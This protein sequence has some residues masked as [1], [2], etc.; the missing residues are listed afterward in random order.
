MKK[1]YLK[2]IQFI[3]FFWIST[4][5]NLYSYEIKIIKKIGSE[6]VTNIDVKKEYQYLKA[7]NKQFEKLDKNDTLIL[8]EE[9]IIRE[10]IKK[11]ELIKFYTLEGV[12]QNYIQ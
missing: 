2:Y 8:A 6:I 12:D 9:S 1:S 10:K 4:N 5:I 3:I 7:L 11:N